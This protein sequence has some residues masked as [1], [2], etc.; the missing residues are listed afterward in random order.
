ME[1][2]LWLSL[3]L[4]L[5]LL[6][7]LA[8]AG[9]GWLRPQ[10]PAPGVLALVNGQPVLQAELD[11]LYASQTAGSASPLPPEQGRQLRLSLLNQLID[12]HMLL[13]Y[14]AN[15]GISADPGAVARELAVE[16]SRQPPPPEAEARQQISD[17]LVLNE[18]MQ[19]EVGGRVVVSDEDISS[20][21]QQNQ[22]SFHLPERQYHVLELVVTPRAAAVTN[23]AEDKA[24]TPAAARK[25]IV[26]L[27][28]RLAAGADFAT[29]AQEYSEDPATASSGGDL[30]LIPQSVLMNQTPAPLRTA[31][32]ALLAGEV[33]P[34]VTTPDGFYLIKL[35]GIEPAGLRALSDPQVKQS[36]RDL[37][38]NARQQVLQ[39]AF[40]TT[41]RDQAKV[42][43]YYARQ[44]L[45]SAGQAG[46]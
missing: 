13:Q 20:F 42:V 31:I 3:G 16:R 43:N 29:L 32:L 27:Q 15:L 7:A 11:Q 18:L 45:E 25:K 4:G 2:P 28:Q 17:N 44:I 40:L 14:A 12:R 35:A 19:R 10:A 37:L 26:M 8:G 6:A 24:A 36:I 22:A 30:G 38:A 46:Q 23:L 34:V 1:Y 5:A 21:Y 9:C 41:V 33:S 39:A